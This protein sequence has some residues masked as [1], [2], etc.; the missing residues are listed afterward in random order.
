MKP[1]PFARNCVRFLPQPSEKTKP[2]TARAKKH[3]VMRFRRP[4]ED[5]N[6]LVRDG[7]KCE[8][9]YRQQQNV[10]GMRFSRPFGNQYGLFTPVH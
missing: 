10:T 6:K 4:S 7:P 3:H 1:I 5:K 9:R 2:P 8:Y